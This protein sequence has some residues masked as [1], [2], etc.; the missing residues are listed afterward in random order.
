[1]L[2][3]ADFSRPAIV[4][5]DQYHW[6]ASPQP[7]VERMMLDRVGSNRARATS[8]VRYASCS[9]FPQH[10][11]PCGKEILVLSG[12]FSENGMDYPKGWYLRNPPGGIDTILKQGV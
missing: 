7:G 3:N 9:W 4:S 8:I 5:A 6:V 11:H 12:L 1:M 2:I 10:L